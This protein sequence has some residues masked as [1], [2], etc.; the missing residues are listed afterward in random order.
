M[1]TFSTNWARMAV[2]YP[3]PVPISSTFDSGPPE[4]NDSVI[5]ATVYGWEMVW[6]KPIG[7]DVSSYAR[8]ANASSMKM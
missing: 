7:N 5:R 6:L 8:C 4:S 3:E 2:W 1:Y